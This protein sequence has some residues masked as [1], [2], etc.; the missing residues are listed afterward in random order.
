MKLE[1]ETIIHAPS[2]KVWSVLG[3]NYADAYKWASSVNSSSGISQ[4]KPLQGAPTVGRV[5]DTELGAFKEQIEAYSGERMEMAY[6]AK[7]AKMPF[8]VKRL[9]NS[10]KVL[11][12]GNNSKVTMSLD[13]K[14]LFPFNILMA[15]PMRLQFGGVLKKA[16]E[17]LKYFVEHNGKPHPR[18]VKADQKYR[19]SISLS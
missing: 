18:K 8:F 9:L 14:L 6:S 13:V 11:P 17:E 4:G 12:Q 3:P 19:K 7:G 5:C 2:T 1:R 10:W 16:H 15:L